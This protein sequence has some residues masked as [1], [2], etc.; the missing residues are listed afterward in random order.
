MLAGRSMT[1][2]ITVNPELQVQ[3]EKLEKFAQAPR[4]QSPNYRMPCPYLEAQAEVFE[5]DVAAIQ[6]GYDDVKAGRTLSLEE[7]GHHMRQKYGIPS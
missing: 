1:T 7:F 2:T 6:R 4:R 5:E 3:L